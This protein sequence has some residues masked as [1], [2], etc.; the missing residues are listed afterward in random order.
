MGDPVIEFFEILV[1][2]D[3]PLCIG[4]AVCHHRIDHHASDS[5]VVFHNSVTTL[6]AHDP[7]ADK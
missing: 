6:I 2:H 5:K 3:H 4:G 1:R 7:W